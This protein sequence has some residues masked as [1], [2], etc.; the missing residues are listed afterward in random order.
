M[1]KMNE[2]TVSSKTKYSIIALALVA[3]SG[4]LSETSMNVT[5]PKLE[6]VFNVPLASIQWVTTAYLL[7]VSIVMPTS[8]YLYRRFRER[9]LFFAALLFFTV[10]DIV[11]MLSVNF[12]MLIVAR[13]IQGV[14]TGIAVPLMFNIILARVPRSHVGAWMGLGGMIIS[15]APAIGPTY[16]GLLIGNLGW[17]AIFAFILIV[18]VISFILGAKSIENSEKK[19]PAQ[20]DFIAFVLMSLMLVN[21][22]LTLNSLTA[23]HFEWAWLIVFVVS[24]V[25]FIYRALHSDKE[26]LDIRVFK[27][28][29]FTLSVIAY[30]IFQFSN[31]GA[32][33]IIPNFL[34]LSVGLTS[35]LAGLSLLPGTLVGA[36][37]NHS[38]GSLYDNKGPK[39]GFW[40]GNSLYVLSLLLFVIFSKNLG[41]ISVI[42]IYILFTLGRSMGFLT[43]NTHG[44]TQVSRE[45]QGSANAVFQTAQQFAASAGTVISSLIVT[46]TGNM[47]QGTQNVF[48]LFL[49]L[50]L[51]NFIL[52]SRILSKQK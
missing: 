11:G 51:L 26:F 10:G 37:S 40:A 41:L 1:K 8:S 35:A 21:L 6:E 24:L 34:Q 33:M 5:F 25:A 49:V 39:I 45:E 13:L 42:L 46:K 22:L 15:I 30:A 23:V 28:T 32:N 27:N 47:M 50:G 48:I 43:S 20:L 36:L 38:I 31:I 44:V 29:A 9:P 18:P 12:S 2:Q 52:F 3:F 17:R 4:I 7:A 16:G 19:S 14:G